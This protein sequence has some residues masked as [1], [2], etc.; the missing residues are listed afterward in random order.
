MGDATA[1]LDAL[2]MVTSAGSAAVADDAASVLAVAQAPQQLELVQSFERR[3]ARSIERR[4]AAL[5]E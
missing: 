1:A 4:L 2:P 3:I 5:R